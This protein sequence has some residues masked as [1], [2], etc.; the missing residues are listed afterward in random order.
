MCIRDRYI[1][2]YVLTYIYWLPETKQNKHPPNHLCF[3]RRTA[4]STACQL[5]PIPRIYN[6]HR[7]THVFIGGLYVVR[8]AN[9]FQYP[10]YMTTTE[11]PTHVF[12][13]G[14]YVVRLANSFRYPEYMTTTEP[15]TFSSAD[16]TK[17][18]SPITIQSSRICH[19]SCINFQWLKNNKTYVANTC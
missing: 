8:L 1:F 14:T 6:H 18:S 10:E 19:P 17:Y 15:P 12:V 4:R 13:S 7:T 2:I 5:L 3:R 16:R 11:P 9:Y